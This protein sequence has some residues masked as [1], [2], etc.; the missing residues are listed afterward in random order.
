[1]F[2]RLCLRGRADVHFP[3]RSLEGEQTY[4]FIIFK[5]ELENVAK[6]KTFPLVLELPGIAGIAR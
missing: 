1:M 5:I 2:F 4:N 6:I 3:Q